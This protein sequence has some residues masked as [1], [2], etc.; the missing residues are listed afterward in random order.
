MLRLW[1]ERSPRVELSAGAESHGEPD[2]IAVHG[3][4]AMLVSNPPIGFVT[5]RGGD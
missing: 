4:S 1:M 5:P 3:V 2:R